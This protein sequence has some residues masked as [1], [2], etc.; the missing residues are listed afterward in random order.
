L[1]FARLSTV[2]RVDRI[3]KAFQQMPDEKLI[4][5]YGENDPQRQ[6]IFDLAQ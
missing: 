2:K 3:V 6:E 1:S 5:I 4:V